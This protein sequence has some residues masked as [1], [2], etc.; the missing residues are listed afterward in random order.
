MQYSEWIRCQAGVRG[1]LRCRESNKGPS[2]FVS[3]TSHQ[4]VQMR[5]VANKVV[6][7]SIPVHV[8]MQSPDF[9][10]VFFYDVLSVIF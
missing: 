7:L 8:R 3:Q 10:V 6:F 9:L 5:F 2:E 1:I 4:D